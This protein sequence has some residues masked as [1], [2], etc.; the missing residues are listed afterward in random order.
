MK[1]YAQQGLDAEK[2]VYKNRHSRAR[3]I[4]E[5]LFGILANRW[6]FIRNVLLLHPDVIEI[7]VSAALVLHN[8]LR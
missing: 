8:F 7:L 6:R 5:N 1:P 3:R 4:S 2:R